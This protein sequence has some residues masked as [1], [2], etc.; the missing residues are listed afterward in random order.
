MHIEVLRSSEFWV[1]LLAVVLHF[2]V[3]Q[4]VVS[5]SVADF[6]N[7]AIVYIVGRLVGKAAK[8]VVKSGVAH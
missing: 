4:G 3:Q 7:M 2:L 8:A 1:G 5:Q 6:V